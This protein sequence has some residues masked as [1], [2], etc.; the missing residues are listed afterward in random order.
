MLD[1]SLFQRMSSL[2]TEQRASTSYHRFGAPTVMDI[3]LVPV[4]L[5]NVALESC[6]YGVYLVLAITSIC[7]IVGRHTSPMRHRGT[8]IH[9]FPILFGA[10][11]LLIT[12]SAHWILTV[13]RAFLAFIHFADTSGTLAFYGDLSEITEVVKTGFVVATLI[14]G[15][16]L[17]IYRLWVVWGFNKY[18]IIFPIASLTGSAVSAAGI[19]YQFTLYKPGQNVF[20]SETGRWI[21]SDAIFTLCINVY[22]T[23]FISW[24]LWNQG[25]AIQPYGGPSLRSV[26]AIIVES[27]ALYTT[28]A[29]TYLAVYRSQSNLQFIVIDCL[30]PIT[31]ISI[32]LI[33]V[34]VGLAQ[35]KGEFSAT[36][37]SAPM[38]SFAVNISRDVHSNADADYP[39]DKLEEE[40]AKVTV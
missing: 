12:I 7:L 37:A 10:I 11:G 33:H 35:M 29:I 14:I 23:A 22:C 13:D 34:R 21:T 36:T 40:G 20:L 15:D 4:N 16:A 26:L 39:M 6:L 2:A 18:V 27:A 28:W 31:G 17:I 9:R 19:T 1:L 30:S 8:L 3:S 5:A 38:P 32:M 25:R 24:R